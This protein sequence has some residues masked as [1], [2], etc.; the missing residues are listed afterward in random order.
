MWSD[1]DPTSITSSG[2]VK[3][4]NRLVLAL[5]ILED[6]SEL[7]G[8]S[9]GNIS[10]E[11]CT[12]ATS[13]KPI[14]VRGSAAAARSR[15]MAALATNNDLLNKS[16]KPKKQPV[17]LDRFNSPR[18]SRV[19]S[20]LKK[21]APTGTAVQIVKTRLPARNMVN[22]LVS[23]SLAPVEAHYSG[24]G[25]RYVDVSRE[26]SDVIVKKEALVKDVKLRN[27]MARILVDICMQMS[28]K[29]SVGTQLLLPLTGITPSSMILMAHWLTALHPHSVP[30]WHKYA[31][32]SLGG[33]SDV[34]VYPR[35]THMV[36]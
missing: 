19:L 5:G 25:H 20:G 7:P 18:S 8:I 28:R 32:C 3:A 24:N 23:T 33:A 1:D 9:V 21:R 16:F 13:R 35:V 30:M 31:T 12:K 10:I 27:H 2:V 22:N 11:T 15:G 6:R 14:A 29:A 17:C 34:L 4:Y 26:F 36:F